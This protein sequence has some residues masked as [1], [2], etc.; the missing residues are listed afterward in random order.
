MKRPKL[1]NGILM[2][3][4]MAF[5]GLSYIMDYDKGEEA[6]LAFG[7]IL[8]EM[9]KVLPCAF[10]LL[11]LFEV[12]IKKETVMKNLGNSS[13][14]KG[15]IWALLLAGFSVGGL[16]VAFPLADTLHKKGASLKIIFTYLGFAGV[17]RIPLTL[18][19]ISFLGVPFTLTRLL[20]AGPLVL[21]MGIFMGSVLEKRNYALNELSQSSKTVK[22]KK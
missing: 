20:V 11:G 17:F 15:Y 16:F 12:W 2:A 22:V 19:E 18:F 13:G 21:L 9:F 7:N 14:I 3:M 5:I 10:I 1:I 6:G 8:W 4:F